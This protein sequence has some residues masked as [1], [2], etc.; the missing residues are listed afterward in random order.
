MRKFTLFLTC[1]IYL[2]VIAQ[3]EKMR[4]TLNTGNPIEFNVNDVKDITFV[5][6]KNPLN[7]VGEWF[8]Y[9][10]ESGYFEAFDFHEDKTLSYY[11][12]NLLGDE[13][14]NGTYSCK[15]GMLTLNWLNTELIVPITSH[16]ETFFTMTNGGSNSVYYRIQKTYNMTTADS[17]ISI[18][19]KGDVITYV[20]NAVIGAE[21][22]KI[23]ALQRGS[24][25]AL[26]KDAQLNTTVAYKIVVGYAPGNIIDW[27]KYFKKSID[28]IVAEF[29]SPDAIQTDESVGELYGYTKG[30][31]A[32]IKQIIFCFDKTT[33][34]MYL[35][36]V[37]FRGYEELNTYYSDIAKKYILQEDRS[38]ER[39]KVF[40]DTNDILSA[41]VSFSV[42][43]TSPFFINY[44]DISE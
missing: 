29:G 26:V 31:N 18:G 43:L 42:R 41:T 16:S 33:G 5:D 44:L 10:E 2:Q 20:D 6:D 7:I 8:N 30:Y 9:D 27:T 14:A 22:N 40:Y 13:S 19:N 25:F 36:Q 17:P 15:D 37:V 24:G 38:D 11:C 39:T 3:E 34:K 23:K 32:E 35:V 1:F 12:F 21:D 28:E 4:I